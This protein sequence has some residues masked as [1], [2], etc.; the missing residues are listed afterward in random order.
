[1]HHQVKILSAGR[2]LSKGPVGLVAM[3]NGYSVLGWQLNTF[4][5]ALSDTSV[6]VAI[7]Y[8]KS[9]IIDSFPKLKF[10]SVEKW[11]T[12]TSLGSFFQIPHQITTPVIS[13]YGDTV[14]HSASIRFLE[15]TISDIVIVVDSTW[16]TRFSNRP[17]S[18]LEKA[19]LLEDS[20]GRTCEFTGLVKFSLKALKLFQGIEKE[21][22]GKGFLDLFQY[23][24]QTSLSI[25]YIDICG[26]WSELNQEQDLVQ[27]ILGNKAETL[28]R[29]KPLL[30]AGQILDQLAVS[31]KTWADNPQTVI[32]KINVY[33]S[34][35]KLIF[36]SSSDAE[37]GW[38]SSAAGQF[39]SILDVNSKDSV[40]VSKA[41]SNVFASYPQKNTSD[42]VLIQPFMRDVFMS[43]VAFTCDNNS[44]APYYIVNFD[45]GGATD[46]VTSGS[47]DNIRTVK[48]FRDSTDKLFSAYPDLLSL[49]DAIVDIEKTLNYNKLDIEFATDN[50]GQV[51]IFQVRPIVNTRTRQ[52]I[53][54]SELAKLISLSE[55]RFSELQK[56]PLGI[57]GDF[58]LFSGMTDWNPAEIIGLRPNPLALSLYRY[59]ITDEIWAQQ[60]R[61]F[62]YRDVGDIQLMQIFC[63]QPYIDC[64]LSINSFIPADLKDDIAEKFI[65]AYLNILKKNT[66]LHD[67]LELEIVFTIWTSDFLEAATER[68]KGFDISYDDLLAYQASLKKITTNALGRLEKDTSNFKKMVENHS[69]I[70]KSDTS[71]IR[72]A[73]QLLIECKKYGTKDFAHAA[74]AGFVSINLL[75]SFIKSGILS[76]QRVLDFQ[77]SFSTVLG[78]LQ[79]DLTDTL[80][81]R[82]E[83]VKKY[84]HLR[85]G[86][87]DIEKKAYWEDPIFYFGSIEKSSLTSFQEHDGFS[88]T[89]E[90]LGGLQSFLESL[91]ANLSVESFLNYLRDAIKLRELVKFY[92]SK[93]LSVALDLIIEFTQNDYLIDRNEVSFLTVNDLKDIS[94]SSI[95]HKTIRKILESRKQEMDLNHLIEL[96]IFL[97]EEKDFWVFELEK[98]EGNFITNLKVTAELAFLEG[99]ETINLSEKIVV[100]QNADPGYDW[101]FSKNIA[102][103]IT[104]YGGAN[105]HMAIRCAELGIPAVIGLGEKVY[106]SM[107]DGRIHLDCE[108]RLI[109]HV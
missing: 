98:A 43:G 2:G 33:F 38:L 90:E 54:N 68:F 102:G 39:E 50:S 103:L 71:P 32:E 45:I 82:E 10:V 72:K 3:D 13:C 23:L 5:E 78:D 65:N 59:L 70:L 26:R 60:R 14:F 87:Y 51:Y 52:N 77:K 18:D 96:P 53:I 89:D 1:L 62:G 80:I 25:E 83:I 95:S 46:S 57:L 22:L 104:Q 47:S 12:L 36:R 61:E 7:G 93:N 29:L 88:F 55:C 101:I 27:F 66:H 105:S 35:S 6:T 74:R 67:K 76:E 106:E 21:F 24:K 20:S 41:L 17:P 16:E 81:K 84:G 28:A 73:C 75:R 37:D 34:N 48:I 44:G 79:N 42:I 94:C 56:P 9:E 58:T 86:T 69:L 4:K 40:A 15:S 109:Q 30:K 11:D 91:S 92:F 64:R 85:P 99:N 63:G 100:I 108:K 49:I 31:R 107:R 19:E 97:K 8:G